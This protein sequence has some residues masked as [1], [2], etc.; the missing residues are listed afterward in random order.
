MASRLLFGTKGI[1][2]PICHNTLF[3]ADFLED[4]VPT[5]SPT[6]ATLC[7]SAFHFA[8]SSLLPG[9]RA[10]NIDNECKGISERLH[11]SLAGD[12]SSVFVSPSTIKTFTFIFSGSAGFDLNH[13]A[14]AQDSI[15]F[16]AKAFVFDKSATVLKAS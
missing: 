2:S 5:T 13:S 10:F 4:P 16:F 14:F 9:F 12:K 7:P 15:T 11:A 8:I 6:Y 3:V 1:S